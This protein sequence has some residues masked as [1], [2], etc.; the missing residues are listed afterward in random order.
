MRG[1]YKI[2]YSQFF[3]AS[4]KPSK[5]LPALAQSD[6][7]NAKV[8]KINANCHQPTFH[9]FLSLVNISAKVG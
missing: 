9:L 7:P 2:Q 3:S 4:K 5:V 1:M 6:P 8:V